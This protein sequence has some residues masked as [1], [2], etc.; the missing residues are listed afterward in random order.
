MAAGL[1]RKQRGLWRRTL[2]LLSWTDSTR[3]AAVVDAV[4]GMPKRLAK[5]NTA[6]QHLYLFGTARR[7]VCR[8]KVMVIVWYEVF[9]VAV[10]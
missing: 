5:F 1:F 10:A 6:T 9:V 3:Q 7:S 4:R 2:N 8:L